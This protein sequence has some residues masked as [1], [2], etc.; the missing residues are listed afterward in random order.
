MGF[1]IPG[2]NEILPTCK[3][4]SGVGLFYQDDFPRSADGT[5]GVGSPN[6]YEGAAR[7]EWI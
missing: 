3:E 5:P 2:N 7:G 4:T 1:N 6:A